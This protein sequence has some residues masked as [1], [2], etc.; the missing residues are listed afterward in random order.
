MMGSKTPPQNSA[1]AKKLGDQLPIKARL[2]IISGDEETPLIKVSLHWL[3]KFI[4]FSVLRN[5]YITILIRII[6]AT[7]QINAPYF[8]AKVYSFILLAISSFVFPIRISEPLYPS[9]VSPFMPKIRVSDL[10]SIPVYRYPL[11]LIV[12]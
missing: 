2:R 9:R 11:L 4:C 3:R 8:S 12:N 1:K 10:F 7:I 6:V 5:K